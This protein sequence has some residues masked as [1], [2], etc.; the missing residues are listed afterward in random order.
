[1]GRIALVFGILFLVVGLGTCG[2]VW[3]WQSTGVELQETTLAQ[4]RDNMN[5]YDAFWKSV[6]EMAQIPDKY[7][8]DFK[9]LLVSETKAK[10]GPG[11]STAGFQWFKDREIKFDAG[12]YKKIMNAIEAGRADF[13][14]GQTMLLDKQRR[15]R[16]NH[17]KP[18]GVIC[19]NFTDWLDD[20]DGKLKPPTDL[21]GDGRYTV[22]DYDIVTS[23]RTK[24]AFESGEDDAVNVFGK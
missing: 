23:K 13:K 19:R 3:S 6:K 1:M 20:I 22:F 2:S 10:F 9:D 17:K 7:K 15:A 24:K 16:A 5:R 21:D 11:G 14:R 4:Y 8:D 18:F 12:I